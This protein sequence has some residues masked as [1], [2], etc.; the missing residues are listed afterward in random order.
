MRAIAKLASTSLGNPLDIDSNS[1]SLTFKIFLLQAPSLIPNTRG[2][3]STSRLDLSSWGVPRKW[4]SRCLAISLRFV[5]F[6][7]LDDNILME[8][9]LTPVEQ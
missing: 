1:I 4:S 3:M 2:L 5:S 7:M 6:D 8:Q 9:Q